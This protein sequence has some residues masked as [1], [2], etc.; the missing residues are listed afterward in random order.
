MKA[1]A[2]GALVHRRRRFVA[3]RV[4]RSDKPVRRAA[5]PAV[6]CIENNQTALSTSIREQSAVRA[7]ADKAVGYGI[8]G[9][10]TDGTDPDSIAAAFTWAADRAREGHG[11]ALIEV[12]TMRM[13][14]HAHHD[15]MLYWERKFRQGGTIRHSS[16]TR[17]MQTPLRASSGRRRIRSRRM[18]GVWRRQA[19]SARAI[20]TSIAARRMR[21]SINRPGQSSTRPGR[22]RKRQAPACWRRNRQGRESRCSSLRRG[23]S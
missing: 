2:R 6:F 5:L 9:V 20:W 13:C 7:F 23:W 11:P 18:R 17:P 15:D 10:T 1:A 21:L 4:A 16:A 12:V 22:W 3:R 19:S 8:A 14:G